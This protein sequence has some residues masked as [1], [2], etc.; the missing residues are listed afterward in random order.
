MPREK[1]F[2]HSTL[3]MPTAGIEPGPPA[4]HAGEAIHNS[5][6]SRQ[7]SNRVVELT[8]IRPEHDGSAS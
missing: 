6:A 8:G 2:E 3:L 7:P 4:Q 1:P 5:I